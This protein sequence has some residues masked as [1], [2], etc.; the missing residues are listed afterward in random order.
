MSN[1][2]PVKPYYTHLS[3]PKKPFKS[4]ASGYVMPDMDLPFNRQPE[5]IIMF[6]VTEESKPYAAIETHS[7]QF[8]PSNIIVEPNTTPVENFVSSSNDEGILTREEILEKIR[9][10]EKQ[11]GMTSKEF[12]TQWR[13][14]IAPDTYETNAWAMLL[15]VL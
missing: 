13:A 14:G 9:R 2:V 1:A 15:D 4:G 11:F 5:S 12:L 7:S 6:M 8:S 10:Y 3:T